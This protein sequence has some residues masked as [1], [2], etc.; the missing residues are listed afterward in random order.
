MVTLAARAGGFVRPRSSRRRA[1]PDAARRASPARCAPTRTRCR[2]T[3]APGSP[4]ALT[5][6][7][8]W[9][10]RAFG[11]L[12]PAQ[13]IPWL[14]QYWAPWLLGARVRRPLRRARRWTARARTRR[15]TGARR[16]PTTG[17]GGRRRSAR[18]PAS[19]S[20]AAASTASRRPRSRSGR[21]AALVT[22]APPFARTRRPRRRRRVARSG[23]ARRAGDVELDGEATR[24]AAPPGA[25]PGRAPARGPLAPSPA[26][27]RAASACAAAGARGS[28]GEL[29]R[30]RAGG[31]RYAAWFM[32]SSAMSSSAPSTRSSSRRTWSQTASGGSRTSI[33][34]LPQALE[35]VVDRAARAPRS[36]RRCRARRSRPAGT[37]TVWRS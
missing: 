6:R 26:R 24:P 20:P 4:C 7:R 9:P 15:R 29:D 23:R 34:A 31:R 2:S 11:P 19:R 25:D 27:P 17:G 35:P 33:S 16:S 18:T 28:R 12:G 36:G 3:S 32:T 13:T 22:L 1:D 5:D 37:S 10:R 14:G 8:E 30:R 21:P